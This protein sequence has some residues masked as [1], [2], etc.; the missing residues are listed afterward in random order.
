MAAPINI[1]RLS[2]E[3]FKGAPAWIDRLL[4]WL[5]Q[6]LEQIAFALNKNLTLE[7]NLAAQVKAFSVTAGA[8]AANNTASFL[9]TLKTAPKVLFKGSVV[10][11]GS[12][13]VALTAAVDVNWRY[14]NGNV[15]ITS[16]TGLTNGLTYD[17]VVALF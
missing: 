8:G 11:R 4:G 6:F 2:R 5:N 9:C 17:F 16:I 3:E 10:Q 1:S 15:L 12:N 14:E 7:Q 13:Y